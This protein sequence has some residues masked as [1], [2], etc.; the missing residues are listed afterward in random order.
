MRAA[1][2]TVIDRP[3]QAYLGARQLVTMATI[4]HV[5]DRIPEL[6]AWLHE[7][8]VVA[9]GPPF[10]RYLTIDME[11]ELEVE[12]GVPL[13]E[14]VH[15]AGDLFVRTLPGGRFATATHRGHPDGL[16]E[17]TAALLEW[18]EAEGL[19]WDVHD[20]AQGQ[21]WGCRL[22]VYRTDPRVEPDM[23]RWETD[24]VFQLARAAD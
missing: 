19:T 22:E 8:G 16:I 9:T 15:V 1:G 18:A 17:A 23:E 2:P 21:V 5:A 20:T 24:L 12:A 4:G 7:H 13:A 6:L 3:P 10:L 11:R 14:P